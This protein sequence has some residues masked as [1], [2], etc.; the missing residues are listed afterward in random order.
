MYEMWKRQQE[1]EGARTMY[2][3]E[4]CEIF[5]VKMR[6]A[7]YVGGHDTAGRSLDLAQKMLKLCETETGTKTDERLQA[8]A[9][10]HKRVRQDVKTNSGHCQGSKELEDRR[11][12]EENYQKGIQKIVE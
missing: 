12:K 7:T 9:S 6:K 11:T 8:R 3:P 10:G 5:V 2:R 4:K 1:H